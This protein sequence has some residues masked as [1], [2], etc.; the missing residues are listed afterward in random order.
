M[1]VVSV[2]MTVPVLAILFVATFVRSAFGFGEALIAVPLLALIMPVTV[3]AP[4]AVL[5]SITV[6]ALVLLRDWRHVE[7]RSAGRLV[8]AT[9]IGT[10]L[11]LL[12]LTRVSAQ[13]VKSALGVIIIAFSLYSLFGRRRS[14]LIDDRFAWPFGFAAGVLG[15]A[16]GMNGPPLVVFGTLRGWTAHRFRATLQGY[17]LPASL[18]S[19]IGYWLTGLWRPAVTWYYLVSVP[20][21]LGGVVLGGAAHGRMDARWFLR[22]VHLGLATV[23]SLLILQIFL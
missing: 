17:F 1:T 4:V 2:W 23:G 16:Y 8:V 18:M 20:V 9:L 5:I 19:M 12:L 3:A 6:A 21:V 13:I 14:A 15:G 7:V 22:C 11:G 10:P